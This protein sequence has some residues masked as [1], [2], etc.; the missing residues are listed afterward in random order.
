MKATLLSICCLFATFQIASAQ[1]LILTMPQKMAFQGDTVSVDV[2]T[3]EFD[4]IVSAQFSMH[5]DTSVI[6]YN[7]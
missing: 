6:S 5:W 3:L 1:E 2:L 7:G 4:S